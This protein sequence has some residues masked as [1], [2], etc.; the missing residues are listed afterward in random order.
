MKIYC[1]KRDKLLI[2]NNGEIEIGGCKLNVL[3]GEL[4]VNG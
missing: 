2:A 3:G 4:A 1:H